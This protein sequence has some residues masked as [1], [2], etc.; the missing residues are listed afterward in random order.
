MIA[1][2]KFDFSPRKRMMN[3]KKVYLTDTGFSLLGGAFTENR[4]RLPAEAP[5][6]LIVKI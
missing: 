2:E 4:G 1:S 6:L 5:D 3:P